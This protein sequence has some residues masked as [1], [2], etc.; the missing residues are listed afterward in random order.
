MGSQT[1]AP[2]PASECSSPSRSEGQLDRKVRP[3]GMGLRRYMAGN[4]T[5]GR[6]VL[7]AKQAPPAGH[8][9]RRSVCAEPCPRRRD[10]TSPAS[11]PDSLLPKV[12]AHALTLAQTPAPPSTLTLGATDGFA[13]HSAWKRWTTDRSLPLSPSTPR[14]TW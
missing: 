10:G 3:P 9:L 5:S 12:T 7:T 11:N 8:R 4:K 2:G 14:S 1:R 6:W 13:L